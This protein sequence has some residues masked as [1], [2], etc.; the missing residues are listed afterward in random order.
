MKVFM[1]YICVYHK[2]FQYQKKKK[3]KKK[4]EVQRNQSRGF[5]QDRL[6]SIEFTGIVPV[7]HLT[8]VHNIKMFGDRK[9]ASEVL[10][11][12]LDPQTL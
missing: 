3:K 11:M 1:I 7:T 5:L 8:L 10:K 4:Q 12:H 9:Y 6:Q 2:N